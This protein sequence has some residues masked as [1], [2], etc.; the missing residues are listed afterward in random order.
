MKTQSIVLS[1][2]VMAVYYIAM[3]IYT[4]A[5]PDDGVNF[6]FLLNGIQTEREKLRSG[7][8]NGKG[9]YTVTRTI[10]K[11]T[12]SVSTP[13]EYFSA[14]DFSEGNMRADRKQA[15][16]KSGDNEKIQYKGQ[17]IET[18]QKLMY[19]SYREDD[20]LNTAAIF[21]ADPKQDYYSF[22][23]RTFCYPLDL[24]SA[25]F[26]SLR[27]MMSG[28]K[29]FQKYI[30][31]HK[32]RKPDLIEESKDGMCRFEYHDHIEGKGGQT[33]KAIL[34]VDTKNGYT[35]VRG[36]RKWEYDIHPESNW[37]PIEKRVSWKKIHI[38]PNSLLLCVVKI[39]SGENDQLVEKTE[40]L[41]MAF[42]WQD[43][44]KSVKDEYFSFCDFEVPDLTP[45]TKLALKGESKKRE[46]LG[47][48]SYLCGTTEGQLLSRQLAERKTFK[49]RL[50]LIVSGL[51][52]IIIGIALKFKKK[53]SQINRSIHGI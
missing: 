39:A 26:M 28:E 30:E 3:N 4:Q 17:Y 33:V 45:V 13:M 12:A 32:S 29:S 31:G 11:K 8:V 2:S 38:M 22:P 34:W 16:L 46:H 53:V 35:I 20:K 27:S 51:V 47:D 18:P 9:E 1:M 19:C 6:Q 24:R 37:I 7:L 52:L 48:Y 42:D 36:Q 5:A 14:F 41:V 50:F 44:N 43:I 49:I 40:K 10:D 25:G 21:I 23:N 15:D